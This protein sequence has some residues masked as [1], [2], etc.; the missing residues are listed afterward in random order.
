[1]N[2][3]PVALPCPR[4]IV[5]SVEMRI[6][7]A[8]GPTTVLDELLQRRS[9]LAF[10]LELLDAEV[11]RAAAESPCG[12]TDDSQDVESYDGT[13]GVTPQFVKDHERPVGQLQWLEDLNTRF[14]GPGNSPGNVAGAR[15]GSG[16]L[17]TKRLFVTAGHCFDQD[18]GGW[19]RP[20]RAGKT[21]SPYEIAKLMRVNFNYQ[22]NGR[23]GATRPASSFP[24]DELVEYRLGDVDYAIA[25]LGHDTNGHLPGDLF[26]TLTI[27]TKDVRNPG[28][29]LCIIQHPSGKPKKI[30]AGPMRNNLAGKITY[31]SIDTF[32]GSSGSPVIW[33]ETGE[34]VGIHTN[35][36][37]QAISGYNRGV[38]VGMIRSVSTIL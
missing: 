13:L 20:M 38:A 15:W 2:P 35:G 5:A 16:C 27:A 33:A 23:T 25:K 8:V 28:A 32:G 1:M 18:G 12:G 22:V 19:R 29:M 30:E 7:S 4:E 9:D 21:I 6:K 11:E 24:I 3:K 26:G 37:C 34:V 10:Q 17:I 31:D 36:G 14:T